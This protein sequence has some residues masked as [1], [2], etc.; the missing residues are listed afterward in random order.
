MMDLLRDILLRRYQKPYK[1]CLLKRAELFVAIIIPYLFYI[2][3]VSAL[4]RDEMW[5]ISYTR[6]TLP[7]V[8][9]ILYF[10]H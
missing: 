7:I 2:L 3:F 9:N 1:N 4:Q 8:A 6:I 5:A 10:P